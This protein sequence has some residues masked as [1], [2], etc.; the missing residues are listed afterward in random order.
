[1][2]SRS[3]HDPLT[4]LREHGIPVTWAT[5]SLGSEGPG[6]AGPQIGL[7]EVR[8]W[9]SAALG[10]EREPTRA[11][12][13]LL[14]IDNDADARRMIAEL[15]SSGV[16][17]QDTEIRKWQWLMLQTVLADLPTNAFYAALALADFW[18]EFRVDGARP[19][20]HIDLGSSWT[21][22]DREDLIVE[23]EA[24]LASTEEVLRSDPKL[25]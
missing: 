5:V 1:M 6:S 2:G 18:S 16:A 7:S 25:H 14:A 19:G 13:V 11:V 22:K 10:S 4:K 21:E 24:W 15:G 9:L 20:P 8:S 23:H 17:D 3:I 12:D